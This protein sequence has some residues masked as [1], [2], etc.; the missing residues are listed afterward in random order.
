MAAGGG[1]Y[2]SALLGTIA[3]VITLTLFE[4]LE[5]KCRNVRQKGLTIG[6]VCTDISSTLL[7]IRNIATCHEATLSDVDIAQEIGE[8]QVI[9]HV[10]AKFEFTKSGKLIDKNCFTTE[11][12]KLNGVSISKIMNI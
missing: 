2:E 6:I 10:T 7:N 3:I 11:I 8:N 5:K 1:F 12:M 4:Y 9:Y